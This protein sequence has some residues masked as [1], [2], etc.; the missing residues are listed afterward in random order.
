MTFFAISWFHR[1]SL[2]KST[3]V[4]HECIVRVC[5][6]RKSVCEVCYCFFFL[7]YIDSKSNRTRTHIWAAVVKSRYCKMH[8]DSEDCCLFTLF[9][10][11]ASFYGIL[12]PLCCIVWFPFFFIELCDANSGTESIFYLQFVQGWLE[13]AHIKWTE[14]FIPKKMWNL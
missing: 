14:E 4:H 13:Q 1:C 9:S 8:G 5:G 11:G 10:I 7:H 2:I 6:A 12:L 3:T